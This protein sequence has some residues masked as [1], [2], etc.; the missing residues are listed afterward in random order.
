MSSKYNI[1]EA[2]WDHVAPPRHP[3][4]IDPEDL[5]HEIEDDTLTQFIWSLE[6]NISKTSISLLECSV[7]KCQAR[8]IDGF[9]SRFIGKPRT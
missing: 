4:K 3:H 8:V 1:K 7:C 2:D 9:D 5:I 6:P